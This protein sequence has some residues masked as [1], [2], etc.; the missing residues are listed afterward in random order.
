MTGEPTINQGWHDG[1][2]MPRNATYEQRI[3]WHIEHEDECG[4]RPM[5][6]SIRQA[7]DDRENR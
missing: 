3:E 6:A 4:C 2:P 5:P 1:H 7:I